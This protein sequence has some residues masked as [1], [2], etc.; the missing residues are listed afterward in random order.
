M[1]VNP[2]VMQQL[3]Q[4]AGLAE[5]DSSREDRGR[6]GGMAERGGPLQQDGEQGVGYSCSQ[7]FQS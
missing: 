5:E 2:A 6:V 3:S 7:V 1:S 4:S